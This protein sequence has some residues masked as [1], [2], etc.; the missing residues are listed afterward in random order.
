MLEKKLW[1]RWYNVLLSAYEDLKYLLNR[2]YRKKYALE[3]V[4]NHYTLASVERYF[5]TRCVFSDE[6]IAK[7]KRKILKG[8]DLKGQVLG[9]D[10]FNVLITLESVIEGKAILCEDGLLRDLK[11]QG[12]YRINE[13][14]QKVLEL[15][16]EALSDLE[17]GEVWFL[18]DSPVSRSREVAKLTE[19]LMGNFGIKGKASLSKAPDHDLKNF[20]VVASSDIGIIQKVPFIVDLPHM[21]TEWKGLKYLD[22]FEIL[23][24]PQLL[25]F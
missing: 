17:L 25:K 5:L 24:K 16:M 11:H 2:G 6:E 18:Y 3:F 8:E 22:F 10:G 4:A 12:G 1:K 15:V 7:R 23:K 20:E 9:V 19:K 13:N 21:V 14:T